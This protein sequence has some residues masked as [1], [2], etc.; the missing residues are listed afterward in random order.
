MSGRANAGA[1][2]LITLDFPPALQQR[3][4]NALKADPRSVDLRAQAPHFYALGARVLELFEDEDLVNVLTEVCGS[5]L[6]T[7]FSC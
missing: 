5:G 1:E 7:N 2:S 6:R 3:V 4:T